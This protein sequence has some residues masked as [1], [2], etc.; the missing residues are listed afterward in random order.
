MQIPRPTL[1]AAD[2]RGAARLATEAA[3]GLADVVE[4]MHARIASLSALNRE[5]DVERAS[6]I[7]GLVYETVRGVARIAGGTAD[8]LLG[9]LGPDPA[10]P[11][12]FAP[13]HAKRE[14]AVAALNGVVGDHLAATGNPLAIPMSFRLAGRD[15]PLERRAMRMRLRDATSRPLV[16][17][18]GLCMNDLQW[19]REGHDHGEALARESGYTAIYLRYNTGLAVSTNGRLL[20]RLIER[21]CDAWPVPIE[22][23]VLLG[24]SMG[25]LVARSA[26][27]HGERV[28]RDGLRR[29]SP[30]TDLVCLGTPHLG[31]PLER[32]GHGIEL[33]LGAAPFAAPLARVAR[34]RSA[35][36]KDLRSGNIV[37]RAAIDSRRQRGVPAGLPDATRCYAIAASLGASA[38]GL[39]S[40]LGS[41]L[42]G[43]GLVTVDSALGRHHDAALRLSFADD[44]QAVVHRTGH[45]GLLSS[46]EVFVRL[47]RWLDGDGER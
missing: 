39:G 35:G 43:D 29:R 20:A 33:L 10:L 12:S 41:R 8:A 45:L 23:L 46:A 38:S 34:L 15:L 14:A 18:H 31:A 2:L 47:R 4:A 3:A 17:L 28:R 5:A 21:L 13:P 40:R 9:W 24:H 27:Q 11:V 1:Q 22:R 37:G 6:G 25:G 44:R 19:R 42:L 32:G 16:L 30:V 26:I 7:T 36:I